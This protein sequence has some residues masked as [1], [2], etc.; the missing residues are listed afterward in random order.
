M[1]YVFAFF[2]FGKNPNASAAAD[3]NCTRKS[4]WVRWYKPTGQRPGTRLL[5]RTLMSIL[6]DITF[7]SQITCQAV[8]TFKG[9]TH[10]NRRSRRYYISPPPVNSPIYVQEE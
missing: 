10:G 5:N 3:N 9:K 1:P 7:G 8:Y 6:R 4:R 2:A